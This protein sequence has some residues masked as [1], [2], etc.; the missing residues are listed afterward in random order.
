M[1][2]TDPR[3][4][5]QSQDMKYWENVFMFR[6]IFNSDLVITKRAI[7]FYSLKQ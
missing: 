7:I 4:I 6:C 3:N 2:G 1:S 5:A